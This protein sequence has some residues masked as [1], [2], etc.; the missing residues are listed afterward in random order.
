MVKLI[1]ERY[2]QHS[3]RS[4]KSEK[5]CCWVSSQLNIDLVRDRVVEESKDV[6]VA[7]DKKLAFMKQQHDVSFTLKAYNAQIIEELKLFKN[8]NRCVLLNGSA[9]NQLIFLKKKY[10][11]KKI[12]VYGANNYYNEYC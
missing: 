2:Q 8:S 11:N 3:E 6:L 4:T 5:Y 12:V 9:N 7:V 1:V 10:V